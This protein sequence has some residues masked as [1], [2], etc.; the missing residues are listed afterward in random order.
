MQR[1]S[2][3]CAALAFAPTVQGQALTFETLYPHRIS[4]TQVYDY[5]STA[6]G[7]SPWRY[8]GQLI[9]QAAGTE[10]RD[11]QRYQTVVHRSKD[12]PDF[13]PTEWKTFHRESDDG[14]YTAQLDKAGRLDETLEFPASAEAGEPWASMSSSFWSRE[15]PE[16]VDTVETGAGVFERCVRVSRRNED[17]ENE[18]VLTNVTTYCPGVGA[19]HELTAFVAPGVK[20]ATE[21]RLVEIRPASE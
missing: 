14:L 12:L 11:G 20:T 13:F 3:L 10:T 16:R 4:G 21:V 7:E 19:V 5:V 2:I 18:Q 9:R 1:I 15:V 8:E 6:E 17:A